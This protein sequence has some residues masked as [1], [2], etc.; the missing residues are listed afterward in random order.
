M[1]IPTWRLVL[2]GGAIVVL[3]ALGVG[4]VAAS[5]NNPGA[6]VAPV[7]AA[8]SLDPGASGAPPGAVRAG[9]MGRLEQLLA[10]RP[11]ARRMVH[12]TVTVTG[13]NGSFVTFQLDHGTI[14]AI[15]SG[16][17]SISEAG[18]A[19]VTVSTD[20]N[21]VV[22]LGGGAGKG[23]LADLKVGDQVFVQSRLDGGTALAKH[24]LR[25]PVY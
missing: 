18:G 8:P 21:T 7:A 16:T 23:S 13:P 20:A 10:N 22:L 3:V 25:V 5:S 11:F 1:R 6:T 9:L 19:T 17:I 12:A 24:I 14:A 4:L 2:T 15:G